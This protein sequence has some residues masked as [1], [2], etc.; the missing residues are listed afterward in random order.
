ME[1]LK[2][3]IVENQEKKTFIIDGKIELAESNQKLYNADN[4]RITK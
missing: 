1:T 2:E 4:S 3:Y